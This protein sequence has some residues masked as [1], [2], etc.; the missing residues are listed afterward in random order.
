MTH[1]NAK[2]Q[3]LFGQA[4]HLVSVQ[5]G[6]DQDAL[7]HVTA[8]V[9][10]M[11]HFFRVQ[12]GHFDVVPSA[13][14]ARPGQRELVRDRRLLLHWDLR[15]QHDRRLFPV[16][17]RLVGSSGER[18]WF[19]G[20]RGEGASE[21]QADPLVLSRLVGDSNVLHFD[22]IGVL[23]GRLAQI[24]PSHD[25]WIGEEVIWRHRSG[26]GFVRSLRAEFFSEGPHRHPL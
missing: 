10:R 19:G 9:L 13:V 18:H 12:H 21:P 26:H 6:P 3:I 11:L 14:L 1:A 23:R 8:A 7:G 17:F 16:R 4:L 22:R 15:R 24:D 25:F 20:V 2:K 5:H